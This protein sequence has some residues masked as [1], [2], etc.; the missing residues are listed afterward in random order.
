MLFNGETGVIQTLDESH[1]NILF[2]SKD[3]CDTCGLK[4]VCAPGKESERNLKLPRTGEFTVGQQVRVEELSN[5]ELHL[6]LIQFGFPMAMFLVGLLLGFFL[7]SGDVLPRE[8]VGFL[9]A[10]IGLGISFFVAR[11]Q[12]ERIVDLIPEKYIRIVAV[13]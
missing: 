6:S 4:V 13:D 2:S 10:C 9:A 8:L 5:L 11:K 7:S 12:V 1:I 3:A